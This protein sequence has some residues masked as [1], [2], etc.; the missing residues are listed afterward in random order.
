[1][2]DRDAY[3][4]ARKDLIVWKRRAQKAEEELDALKAR[5]DIWVRVY[6]FRQNPNDI[7]VDD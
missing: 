2:S 6:A 4:V 5:I 7:T 3:E 1:M